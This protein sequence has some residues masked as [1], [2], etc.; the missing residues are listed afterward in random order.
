[1]SHFAVA[2]FTDGNT[3]A[4]SL[5]EP[6]YEGLEVDKYLSKTRDEL[7][8]QAREELEEFKKERYSEY[9]K[10]P[11]AYLQNHCRGNRNDP[12][13]VYISTEFLDRY[14]ESD[15]EVLKREYEYYSEDMID[16]EGNVY[17]TY[18]PKSKW[19]WYSEGGRFSGMLMS[20]KE[21]GYFD[22]L[23]V[24]DI[25]FLKMRVVEKESLRQYDEAISDGFYKPEYLK[26]LYPTPEVYEKIQ[27]EFWT[28]AVVTP[29]GEWSELGRMGWFGMS[30]EEPED[31]LEWVEKYYERFIEP[32][33][34]NGWTLNIIDCHI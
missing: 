24:K 23:P 18:N 22:V 25:N 19:D 27:T 12:H 34:E 10:D 29:D 4:D 8:K 2:V 31:T 28:R 13:F 26:R 16:E 33:I 14:N 9:L 32:A 1:M 20:N 21:K 6:Y 7:L 30:S 17:S 3:S 11:E 5:L 15:E